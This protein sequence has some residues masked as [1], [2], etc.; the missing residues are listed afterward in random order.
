MKKNSILNGSLHSLENS[1]KICYIHYDDNGETRRLKG[2]VIKFDGE[3]V[4]VRRP[5][6]D[7]VYVARNKITVVEIPN[8]E[9]TP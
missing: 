4:H 3:T 6:G 2:V 1:G 9:E 8:T 5:L 7:E